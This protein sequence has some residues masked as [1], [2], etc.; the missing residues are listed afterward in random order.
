MEIIEELKDKI[1]KYP[2]KEQ[3][4]ILLKE[5]ETLQNFFCEAIFTHIQNVVDRQEEIDTELV[6]KVF[7]YTFIDQG[8]GIERKISITANS[9]SQ[10]KEKLL[11]LGIHPSYFTTVEVTYKV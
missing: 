6:D 2:P 3:V 7:K 8:E 4:E 1:K 11:K 9:I 10:A 5:Y